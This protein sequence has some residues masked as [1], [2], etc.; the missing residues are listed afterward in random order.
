[1]LGA[2]SILLYLAPGV[3]LHPMCITA[4]VAETAA[5]C[6]AVFSLSLGFPMLGSPDWKFAVNGRSAIDLHY[7]RSITIANTQN[8]QVTHLVTSLSPL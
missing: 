7:S 2:V 3:G 5:C 1:M 8:R 4:T 6:P